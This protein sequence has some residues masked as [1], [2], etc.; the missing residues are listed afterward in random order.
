M[1]TNDKILIFDTTLRDGEQSPGATM[2]VEEKLAI[3][4][5]LEH[6]GV[7][8]IEAGFAASSE[9]DFDAVRR[10]AEMVRAHP[11]SFVGMGTLP[12]QDTGKAVQELERVV[13]ELGFQA[14]E[15]SSH[16]GGMDLDDPR[17]EPFFA[18]A[19]ELE[20]LIFIHPL[21]F[22]DG[23]RLKDYLLGAHRR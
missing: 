23:E 11:T 17:F 1:A 10:V 14:V 22:T 21:G 3:A 19:Q 18:K 8:V 7:D 15:V 20:V 4:R 6:L 9:G 5:Q 16:V 2:N 12:L 13:K